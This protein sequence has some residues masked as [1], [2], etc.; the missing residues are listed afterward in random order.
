MQSRHPDTIFLA[1]AFSRPRVMFRLAKL[2]FSQSYTYFT[3]RNSKQELTDYFTELAATRDWFRPNLW[4]NTPDILHEYLQT[5]GRPAFMARAALAATLGASWGVYGPAY[6]LLEHTPRDPPSEEYL[7]S[8]KY[9]VRHWD[10]EREDSLRPFLARLNEIRRN[11][12]A[13]QLDTTLR[14]H[15]VDNDQL[16]GYS[17]T[18]ADGSNV[19]L[20]VVNLDPSHAQSG[21]VDIPLE[22]W[23]LDAQSAYQAHELLGGAT[24]EWQGPRAFVTLAPAEYPACIYRIQARRSA[25]ERDFDYFI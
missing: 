16:I 10:L 4:P 22:D 13:L 3:W 21:F 7:D 19:V 15:R 25:S 23:G 14:F 12:A 11:N 8:E 20:V 9:E 5:G 24:F 18:N 1:E 17:K 2:G 6:E